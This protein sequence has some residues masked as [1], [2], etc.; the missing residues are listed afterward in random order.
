VGLSDWRKLME[1]SHQDNVHPG[2]GKMFVAF[3][4]RFLRVCYHF[5]NIRE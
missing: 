3:E 4:R 5:G 1:V 2:K